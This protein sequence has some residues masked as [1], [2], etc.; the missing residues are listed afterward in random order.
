MSP[1]ATS[2]ILAQYDARLAA[3]PQSITALTGASF[4]RW[5]L[6]QYAAATHLLCRT[7][8]PLADIALDVGFADQSHFSRTYSAITGETP[9]ECRHRHR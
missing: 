7:T 3:D 1:D 6:F 5:F 9:S 8:R 4:A 2:A